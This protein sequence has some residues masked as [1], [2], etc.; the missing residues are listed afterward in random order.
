VNR[1]RGRPLGSKNK[2]PHRSRLDKEAARE[3]VRELVKAHIT[4]MTLAQIENAKGIKFLMVRAKATGKFIRVT[5]AM[6]KVRSDPNYNAGEEI[7]EVWEKDP[8]IQAYA[9]LMNRTIDKPVEQVE[10]QHSGNVR[11]LVEWQK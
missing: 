6:A 3:R 11:M 4:P 1:G 2:T 8:S 5:E 10:Q 9:D 7:I